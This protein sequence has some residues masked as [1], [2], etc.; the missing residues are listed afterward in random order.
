[1]TEDKI[2]TPDAKVTIITEEEGETPETEEVVETKEEGTEGSG[3][4]PTEDYKTKFSESTRENQRILEENKNLKA[5]KEA[6]EKSLDELKAEK[7]ELHK[8]IESENPDRAEILRLEKSV[9]SMQ[10]DILKAK[11]DT[12]VGKFL[13]DHP[14]ADVVSAS[15]R[16]SF[17]TNPDKSIEDIW[18]EDYKPFADKLVQSKTDQKI[19]QKASQPESGQGSSSPEPASVDVDSEAFAKLSLQQQKEVLLK[20]GL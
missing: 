5:E 12:A 7:E 3:S 15:L 17:R 10:S 2:L 18:N 9:K 14:E 11:E 16:R 1:M 4:G 20:K 13:K 8:A 19:A 6:M